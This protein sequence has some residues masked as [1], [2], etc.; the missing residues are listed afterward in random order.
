MSLSSWR[1]NG[2]VPM[3]RRRPGAS[4]ATALDPAGRYRALKD[5]LDLVDTIANRSAVAGEC[6]AIGQ[7]TGGAGALRRHTQ[8]AAWRRTSLLHRQGARAPRT[9]PAGRG[10]CNAREGQGQLPGPAFPRRSSALRPRAGCGGPQRR[11]ARPVREP[12]ARTYP[13]PEPSVRQ[14]QLLER[15][16]RRDQAR[17][18]AD[19]VVR[20][21]RRAPGHVRANEREWFSLAKRLAR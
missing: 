12:G 13:G 15:L 9:R 8:A 19:E 16:G 21:L 1:R 6:L 2:S 20:S 4:V 7:A 3:G 17:S 18:I 5:Q 11:G 10:G 14:A